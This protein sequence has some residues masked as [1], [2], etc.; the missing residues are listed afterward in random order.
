MYVLRAFSRCVT[1]G[2]SWEGGSLTNVVER[3]QDI[4]LAW[5]VCRWL[6]QVY[7]LILQLMLW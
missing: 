3:L 7:D 1:A 5:A 2:R 4:A 6:D